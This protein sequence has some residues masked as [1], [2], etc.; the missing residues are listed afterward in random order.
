MKFSSAE[1]DL[2]AEEVQRLLPEGI[3]EP[4]TTL[5]YVQ[6]VVVNIDTK[7]RIYSTI[8]NIYIE[9]NAYPLPNV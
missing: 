5:W 6:I 7:G 9:F 8:M 2:I 1:Q 3:V 4:S